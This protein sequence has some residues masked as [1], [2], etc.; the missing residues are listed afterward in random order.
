MMMMPLLLLNGHAELDAGPDGP[1]DEDQFLAEVPDIIPACVAGI[2]EFWKN[3]RIN[4]K[5][6]PSRGR[7]R[8][9][10]RRRQ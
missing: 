6:P 1:V 5:L 9:G 7:S 4:P 8:P 3:R 10:G 2:Y